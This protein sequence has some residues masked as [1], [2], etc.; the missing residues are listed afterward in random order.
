M[1]SVGILAPMTS[2]MAPIVRLLALRRTSTPDGTFWSGDAGGV[3]VTAALA[4]VGP[5]PAADATRRL[6]R[7]AAPDHVVVVGVTGG[8]DPRLRVGDLVVPAV[9]RD[10]A[11]QAE[12]RPTLLPGLD[13]SGVMLT[14]AEFLTDEVV[15]AGLAEDGVVSLDM[16][17]AAVAAVCAEQGV[18][19]SV[20]RAVSDRPSDGLVDEAIFGLTRPDGR[21]DLGAVARLL[22][23]H[24]TR[25]RTLA[26][27]ARDLRVAT[28]A[29]ARAAVDAVR[30]A[31]AEA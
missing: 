30:R 28:N 15:L 12:W 3:R 7:R 22:L 20:V 10:A 16:E 9:V 6:L 24:P 2:E 17:A 25:V 5:A 31:G 26:R 13:A 27:I 23:R 29:A 18:A 14:T 19:W 4:G 8:L 11:S 1:T 21:P